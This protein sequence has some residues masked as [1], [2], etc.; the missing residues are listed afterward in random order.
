MKH[1][2]I[3]NGV[4]GMAAAVEL[5]KGGTGEVHVYSEE[6]YA[7]YY[8]PHVTD[9][10]AGTM[11]LERVIL[12]TEDW[13]AR[14]GI[15]LHLGAPVTR[16]SPDA[17]TM[18]LADGTKVEYDRLLCAAGSSPFVPP[19]PGRE[20][21]GVFTIRT[22]ADAQAIR[23]YAARCREAV[24]IGGGLLGLEAARGVQTLGLQVSLVE[25]QPRLMPLQLDAEGAAILKAFVGGQG[26]AV[27]LADSVD[28]IVG[29]ASVT[30]VT[31]SSGRELRAQLVIVAA[32]VR[33]NT[34]LAEA[35]GLEVSRGVQVDDAMRT[36]APDIYAAGDAAIHE[37]RCWAIV[38]VAQAQARV[39]AANMAGGN[40]RYRETPPITALKVMGIDVSSM[41]VV[42]PPEEGF[43]VVRREN[44]A[45]FSYGKLLLHESRLAGAIVIGNKALAKQV[46]GMLL[47]GAPLDPA[48]AETMLQSAPEAAS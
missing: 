45:A 6:P 15:T 48:A 47:R 17:H 41:G 31:L 42:D 8:R 10:L 14:K 43:T 23:E 12:R 26:F 22:L 32:G 9:Y 40:E 13:Y 11:P 34:A 36:S 18:T 46:E 39:A 5:A 28:V 1:L 4:A 16:L 21:R 3:G 25:L 33:P 7:Y 27:Y 20:I 2:I 44:A 30:G 19:I 24:V 35:A 29:E 37:G 38:P